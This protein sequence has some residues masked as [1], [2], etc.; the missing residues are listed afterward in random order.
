MRAKTAL[1]QELTEITELYASPKQAR[2]D[3]AVGVPRPRNR[4]A[5]GSPLHSAS[6][7]TGHA[8]ALS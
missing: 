5:F 8:K 3:T 4:G 6:E 1:F 7:A 2:K